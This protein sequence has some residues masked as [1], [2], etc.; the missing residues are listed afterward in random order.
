M[1]PVASGAVTR[2]I[3]WDV[4]GTLIHSRGIGSEVF[5]RAFAQVLGLAPT[6]RI[7]ERVRLGGKTDPEIALEYLE[8]MEIEEPHLHLP[9][10]LALL[11]AE[12]AM[13]AEALA[14]N[15]APHPGVP[16][17]LARLA[18]TEGVHQTLLTGNLEANAA[19]KVTAFG[20]DRWLDLKIGAYGSDDH[21]RCQLVPVALERA[22]RLRGL[23]VSPADAW[24]VG[25]TERDLACARAGGARCLLVA[26]GNVPA[27]DLAAIGPDALLADLS[28][29]D[30][31]YQILTA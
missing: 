23:D 19:V 17:L 8:L 30:A 25:D 2:L 1:G 13:A 21:D 3:L 31:A 24:V 15:G 4:D 26:T 28:D 10:V 11:E 22:A 29:V 14:A 20:L 18:A 7:T 27:A 9:Q 6:A 16:E 12:L 5:D